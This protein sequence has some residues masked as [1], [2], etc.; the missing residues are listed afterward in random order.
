MKSLVFLCATA[1]L[2]ILVAQVNCG[3]SSFSEKKLHLI[4]HDPK[5]N[6]FLF[7][8]NNPMIDGKFCYNEMKTAMIAKAK[9]EGNVTLPE[10][11]YLLD[12]S[13]VK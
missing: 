13:F 3:E 8:G 5:T 12:I 10:D 7:R 1:L 2:C 4:D 6:N 11:F 9:L